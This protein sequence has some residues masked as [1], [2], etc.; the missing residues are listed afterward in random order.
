MIGKRE[1]KKKWAKTDG[2]ISSN[3]NELK[4]LRKENAE[5]KR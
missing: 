3:M 4:T 1:Q 5:T 2:N